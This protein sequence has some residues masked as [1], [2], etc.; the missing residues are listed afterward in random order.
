MVLANRPFN[1]IV[2]DG[3]GRSASTIEP[4]F[5]MLNLRNVSR[6]GLQLHP[7]PFRLS[8]RCLFDSPLDLQAM[9]EK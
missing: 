9:A 7:L 6:A 2:Y 5:L 3:T 1:T 8:T 4:H